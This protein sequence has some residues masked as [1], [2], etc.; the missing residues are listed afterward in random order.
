[1][2]LEIMKESLR[3]VE[4]KKEIRDVIGRGT[5]RGTGTEVE[6]ERKAR[7]EKETGR[8]IGIGI[9]IVIKTVIGIVT[10]I[11]ETATGIEVRGGKGVEEEMMMISTGVETT[12]GI[13]NLQSLFAVYIL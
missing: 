7:M 10:V 5:E 8:R 12:T 9:G 3:K 2:F 11:I 6:I 4:K 1:M 13:G